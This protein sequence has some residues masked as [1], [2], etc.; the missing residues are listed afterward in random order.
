M[1]RRILLASA[2][3]MALT[4]AAFAADLRAPPPVMQPPVFTW[5]GFYVGI[6]AGY[7]W[8]DSTLNFTSTDTSGLAAGGGLG[9]AQAFGTIPTTGASGA[10]GFIGGGQTGYNYQIDSFVLGLELDIDG[11]T[12][13]G[14]SSALL[15]NVPAGFDIPTLTQSE[16]RLDWLGTLRARIG[17]T[18]IDRL[19]IYGTG[20]LAF[21][22]SSASFSVVNAAA[23]PP[24]S[25]FAS[26]SVSVGWAAGGGI[27]YAL[28]DEWS[29]WSVKVE[30][31]YYDL[32][33]TTGT[34]FYQN[35][36]LTGAMESSSLTGQIRHNGNIVRA[37]LNY[38]FDYGAPAPVV[39]KY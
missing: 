17:W 33:R 37:G 32:G 20:G 1:L 14:S 9:V 23:V 16:Q 30:Y 5:T 28:P 15:T 6:N 18:P 12:G 38:K 29:N 24:L 11:A 26:N 25:D 2:G 4:S 39:A 7:H 36:D 35:I 22:R 19:L 8:G 3:A 27:E 10:K 21:G 13:T 31:L 34:V